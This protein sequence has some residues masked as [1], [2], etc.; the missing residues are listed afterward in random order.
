MEDASDHGVAAMIMVLSTPEA[1]A[2]LKKSGLTIV[3]LFRPFGMVED[4]NGV[5]RPHSDPHPS[6]PTLP[7]PRAAHAPR[8][9]RRPNR[10]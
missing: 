8:R 1:D 6:T 5:P 3:D 10:R 9:S 4:A 2:I 7:R